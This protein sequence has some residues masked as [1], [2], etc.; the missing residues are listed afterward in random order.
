M[1]KSKK[2]CCL[3]ENEIASFRCK[4]C[5]EIFCDKCNDE[6][7]EHNM[8]NELMEMYKKEMMLDIKNNK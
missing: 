8:T 1:E 3:H 5:N 7:K 2:R 6:H 4:E